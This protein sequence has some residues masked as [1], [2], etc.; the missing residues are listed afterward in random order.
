[1]TLAT[2][3][4]HI[5][6][7]EAVY[8]A[9]ELPRTPEAVL[10]AEFAGNLVIAQQV[11]ME[12]RPYTMPEPGKWKAEMGSE[13]WEQYTKELKALREAGMVQRVTMPPYVGTLRSLGER[14]AYFALERSGAVPT[15]II[16]FHVVRDSDGKESSYFRL[17]AVQ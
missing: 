9:V 17:Y 14:A 12:G 4:E 5:T 1:M 15:A 13:A 3:L 7:G 6:V 8:P 2:S 11:D 16:P 10:A